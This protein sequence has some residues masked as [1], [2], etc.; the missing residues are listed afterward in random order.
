M[1]VLQITGG[2]PSKDKPFFQTFIKSQID[3]LIKEG[4]EIEIYDVMGYKSSLNYLRAVSNI[5]KIV[6]E[7]KI[8]LIH[9]HYSYCGLSA[10]LS[11]ANI[12]IV[13][14]LM[15]S[16]LLGSPDQN[17]EQTLRGKLDKMLS[18]YVAKK[19]NYI[20]VKSEEMKNKL[21]A[22]VPIS[23]IPNGVNFDIF[24]PKDIFE[25]RKKLGFE[26]DDFLVLFLGNTNEPRKNYSL[27]KKAFELFK[28][29]NKSENIKLL[30]PFGI[31]SSEIVEY[32][33]ASNVL[34]LTSYWE[35]SPNVI[36]E[37]MACNLPIISVDVGDVKE[38]I[39]DTFNCFIIKYDEEEIVEKLKI[40]Y[41]NKQRSNGRK[42]I[43]HL[44]SSLIAKKIINIYYLLLTK[45][46][47]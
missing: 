9:A 47:A 3:S 25:S 12:P 27:S 5:K 46:V 32:M 18:K 40:I 13:L 39:K 29:K 37:A 43:G 33:N 31:G 41:Q 36:K 45:K 38:V 8:D 19:V 11:R 16:D 23:V 28:D 14:S 4:I 21:D 34:L 35:G 10:V 42:K 1:K 44:E 15:G 20:I 26:D 6:Q 30:S 2:L 7:K 22:E 24:K 17:G